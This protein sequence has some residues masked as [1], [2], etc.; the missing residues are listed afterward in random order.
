MTI[1][2]KHRINLRWYGGN[3]H[4]TSLPIRTGGDIDRVL[5][6]D[7]VG[8]F[9]RVACRYNGKTY[10]VNSEAGD[11]GDPFRADESYLDTLF[12]DVDGPCQWQLK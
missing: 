7:Q 9:A 6:V 5:N 1:K 2:K 11:I 10:L 4:H 12:I 8:N 3:S